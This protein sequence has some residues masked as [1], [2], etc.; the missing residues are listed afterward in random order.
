MPNIVLMVPNNEFNSSRT[1]KE[2][3]LSESEVDVVVNGDSVDTSKYSLKLSVKC[4]QEGFVEISTENIKELRRMA[5]NYV[6]D[7]FAN[8]HHHDEYSMKD[9]IGTVEQLSDLCKK[10]GRSFVC[11]TNHGNIGGWIRQYNSC[12]KNK[13]KPIFGMEAY[14]SEH[15]ASTSDDSL[16]FFKQ[17]MDEIFKSASH[18]VMIAM[19]ENG[20][21]NLIR[22]HNEAQLNG[23]YY[24]PR[25]SKVAMKKWGKGI[26]ATTACMGGLI[27]KLLSSGRKDEA[28][29]EMRFLK[30]CFDEVYVEI[31]VI[32]FELQREVNRKLISFAR[33][34][35]FPLILGIDSH[36]LCK[37]YSDT[38][39]L[40]LLIRQG[41]TINDKLENP[42]DVW[43]FDSGSM[44][45][46]TY[47]QIVDVFKNGF[48]S[49]VRSKGEIP[50]EMKPFEDDIFTEEVFVEACMNT[51]RVAI[52]AEDIAIDS[53]VKLP[54]LYQDSNEMFRQKLN[55]GFRFR[56]LGSKKNSKDY[57]DRIRYEYDVIK[58][59]GW[60]D[61]FLVMEK[62]VDIT[63]K[64]HGEFALGSGRGSA[65][66]SLV[67]YCLRITDIDPLE[68]G[69][70]FERFLD[71]SR[72][73]T[74]ACKFEV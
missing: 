54:K 6:S 15:R 58:K 73:G 74:S 18:M 57:F 20:F 53:S 19:D 10:Q 25:V 8:L 44:F 27:P 12:R 23:F 70:L 29:A 42:D 21:S 48:F 69:L 50:S 51:R 13:Q 24:V 45:Y 36:Y 3:W 5:W 43:S 30:G 22:I 72:M 16:G 47:E 33:E 49:K 37:E 67:A 14:V 2:L 62:I 61:Y 41:K 64:D 71:E 56:K 65:A 52:M 7:K 60:I 11:V 46:R 26:V 31:Q 1:I 39:D 55:D 40:M 32:E 63:I 9:G 68:Y 4:V 34:Y 59:L 35:G 28:L 66:G 17:E 38:H